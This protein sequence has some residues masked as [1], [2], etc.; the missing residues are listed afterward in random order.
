[1]LYNFGTLGKFNN[2]MGFLLK[3]VLTALAVIVTSSVLPG[4]FIENAWTAVIV[5]AVLSFLNA[6]I[7]PL[8]I[9]LTIPIT[10]FT[11]GFFLLVI[12]AFM[13]L[14]TDRIVDGFEVESFFTAFLFSIV[15][16]IVN[17]VFEG[18]SSSS[19]KEEE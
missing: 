4:V 10:I 9:I 13:I 3:L 1:M 2:C 8:M 15:L 11:L 18:L 7:K 19:K 17:W 6:I 5:A 12:N 14:L 16:S